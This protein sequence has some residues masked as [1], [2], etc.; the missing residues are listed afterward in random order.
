[1]WMAII[2][3]KII[4][5]YYTFRGVDHV[6]SY[7]IIPFHRSAVAKCGS[8]V[9]NNRCGYCLSTLRCVDGSI[10]GPIDGS[11]CPSWVFDSPSD[12]PIVPQCDVYSDC[13]SCAGVDDCA[14]CASEGRC[15]TVTEIFSQECHATVFDPP[16]PLTFVED[17]KVVGNLAVIADP[18]FGG[19]ELNATGPR[20]SFQ[21][22]VAQ[23]EM[24][25]HSARDVDIR[26]SSSD[27][28]NDRGGNITLVAG[29]GSNVHG[30]TGGML[31]FRGGN[32][33][34]P[35]FYGGNSTSGRIIT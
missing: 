25:I 1:M 15:M 28:V 19:G 21:F 8:C 33:H 23:T 30:G 12:C 17:K 11:P 5:N 27:A 35:A 22:T 3:T 4:L 9:D 6:I 26:A 32:G 29:N 2:G 34:G 16:C 13:T 31:H 14:W 10:L 20:G 24:T 7:C 18:M